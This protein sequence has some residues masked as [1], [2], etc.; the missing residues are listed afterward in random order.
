MESALRRLFDFQ[1]F[2][3]NVEL[4]QIIDSVHQRYTTC[5]L[6]ED[7]LFLVNAAGTPDM[8]RRKPDPE[9]RQ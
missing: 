2:E 6:S 7:D 8:N 9:N 4:R 3:N 1:D 5:E